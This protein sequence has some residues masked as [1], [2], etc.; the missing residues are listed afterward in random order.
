MHVYGWKILPQSSL[1]EAVDEKVSTAS[2]YYK[3]IHQ[4][5]KG[6]SV[7]T[8]DGASLVM[9]GLT[10]VMHSCCRTILPDVRRKLSHWVTLQT[11]SRGRITSWH[12]NWATAA[13]ESLTGRYLFHFTSSKLLCFENSS[14]VSGYSCIFVN[15]RLFLVL[16]CC[17]FGSRTW[18]IPHG[19]IP[20]KKHDVQI[21]SIRLV[22]IAVHYAACYCSPV[23][24]FTLLWQNG[25]SCWGLIKKVLTHY[26]RQAFEQF[27][28]LLKTFLLETPVHYK[29][30]VLLRCYKYTF[31]LSYLL[32]YSL[33]HSLTHALF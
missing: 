33:T 21:E 3:F 19:Q 9:S 24:F 1:F 23:L 17:L 6:Y 8:L 28:R 18:A 32:T 12:Q 27:K 31:L 22:N 16:C 15:R 30:F 2:L 13:N 7:L 5:G 20:Q 11:S 29:F 4:N 14:V 10:F 26:G 25:F